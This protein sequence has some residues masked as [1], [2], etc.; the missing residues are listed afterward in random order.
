VT[1]M[2]TETNSPGAA[3]DWGQSLISMIALLNLKRFLPSSNL[4]DVLCMCFFCVASIVSVNSLRHFYFVV[5]RFV[6]SVPV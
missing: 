1:V 6:Y 4:F 2:Y 3:S 5:L